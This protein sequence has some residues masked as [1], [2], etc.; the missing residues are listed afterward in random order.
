M[1]VT[2]ETALVLLYDHLV[3]Q[4]VKPRGPIERRFLSY[5]PVFD[6]LRQQLLQQQP[7]ANKL[8]DLLENNESACEPQHRTARVNL[9]LTNAETVKA[10]L[11]MPYSS[12]AVE[13]QTPTPLEA[14]VCDKHLADVLSLPA[15][16]LAH[17]H[18][19]VESGHVVLQVRLD[20]LPLSL[21]CG[22]VICTDTA[23]TTGNHCDVL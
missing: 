23:T 3:G 16:A 14:I 6:K 7:G 18:P 22:T 19:L 21:F 5:A 11:C 1:Q 13:F 8:S 9:L 2:H 12:W 4:G 20:T 15:K 17:N 10:Q